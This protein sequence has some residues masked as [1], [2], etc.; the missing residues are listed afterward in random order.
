M[1]LTLVEFDIAEQE[2]RRIFFTVIN[3]VRFW[4]PNSLPQKLYCL[5][6]FDNKLGN[7]YFIRMLLSNNVEGFTLLCWQSNA[8]QLP[9]LLWGKFRRMKY[10][11]RS[12]KSSISDVPMH[13]ASVCSFCLILWKTL[14]S[15]VVDTL[16]I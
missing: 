1:H 7:F 6:L 8:P 4:T 15:C 14:R 9:G 10:L 3:V 2:A 5:L 16:Y 13:S 12:R 11:S